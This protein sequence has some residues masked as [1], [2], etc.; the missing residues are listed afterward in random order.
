M[1]VADRVDQAV[2][3]ALDLLVDIGRV[4]QL[5]RQLG[6]QHGLVLTWFRLLL[7]L[8]RPLLA[9]LLAGAAPRRP[10]ARRWTCRTMS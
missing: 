6:G 4:D 8:P 9:V 10:A 5:E 2:E 1:L 3:D 7:V